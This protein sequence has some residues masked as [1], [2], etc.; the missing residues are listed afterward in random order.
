MIKVNPSPV[1][2]VRKQV[3]EKKMEIARDNKN[4]YI[5]ASGGLAGIAICLM[6]YGF[7]KWHTKIQP[8]QDELM[9]LQL[10]KSRAE[11]HKLEQVL[12]QEA[13]GRDD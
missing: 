9:Q 1:D 8:M 6:L 10:R 3:L 13:G 11:V 12:Q 2:D 5:W 7:R 4:F